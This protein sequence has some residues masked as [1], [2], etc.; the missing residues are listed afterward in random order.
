M[1]I[2]AKNV[3][4]C[5]V[6]LMAIAAVSEASDLHQIESYIQIL[7]A[8]S[9]YWMFQAEAVASRWQSGTVVVEVELH[10]TQIEISHFS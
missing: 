6:S 7:Q 8:L 5:K 10:C 4:A 2:V 9:K 3:C 1:Y